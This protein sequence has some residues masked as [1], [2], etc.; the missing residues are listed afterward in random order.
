MLKSLLIIS[1]GICFGILLED[2]INNYYMLYPMITIF[3]Y[4]LSKTLKA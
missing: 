4:T 3:T 2:K 1:T